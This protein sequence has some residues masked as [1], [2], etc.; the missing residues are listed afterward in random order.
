[1][2]TNAITFLG[3]VVT[4]N[5]NTIGEVIAPPDGER[6][7]NWNEV[8]SADSTD[9]AVEAIA[10]AINEG[11]RSM[12]IVYDGSAAGVYNDLNTDFL[13]RTKATLLITMPDTSVFSM[14]AG[15]ATLGMPEA[16]A[17]DGTMEVPLGF[18]VSGKITFTDVP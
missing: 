11:V 4:F 14:T 8:L 16:G 12:R 5:G 10:G 3:G 15:I 1:M 18:K 6:A 2:A 17:V 7:C 9:N 13:A